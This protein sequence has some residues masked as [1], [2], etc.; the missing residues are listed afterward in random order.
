[1]FGDELFLVFN[2][3]VASAGCLAKYSLWGRCEVVVRVCRDQLLKI[4]GNPALKDMP[5]GF[6][7]S[8]LK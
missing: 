7:P 8:V 2:C 3:G 4:G 1:M 6:D 5:L